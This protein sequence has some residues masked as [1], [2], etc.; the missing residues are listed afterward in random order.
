[1]VSDAAEVHAAAAAVSDTENPVLT[2][3]DHRIVRAARVEG[4]RA[5]VEISPTYSGCPALDPIRS[6]V[7]RAVRARGYADVE[8]RTVLAPPWSTDWISEK[9]RR[10]LRAY[11]IAPP[12]R[13]RGRGCALAD[14]PVS[15]PRCGSDRTEMV[16]RF[17]ATP[18]QAHFVCRD[19]AEPFDHF[20]TLR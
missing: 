18:C 11:G 16:S 2:L 7:E 19:C 6:D 10:K 9:G 8:V 17:G 5:V 13:S 3:G 15:C 12:A 4:E 1:V 20:K 14:A